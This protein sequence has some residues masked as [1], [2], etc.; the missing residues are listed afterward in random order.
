MYNEEYGIIGGDSNVIIG[1]DF[2][3]IICCDF[4]IIIGG[5]F[6]CCIGENDRTTKTPMFEKVITKCT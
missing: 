6:N 1:G 2:N 3:V 4:I 5:D